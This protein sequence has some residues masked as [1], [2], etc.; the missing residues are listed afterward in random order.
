MPSPFDLA[1]NGFKLY[2]VIGLNFVRAAGDRKVFQGRTTALAKA[3]IV[4][5]T[6]TGIRMNFRK[7]RRQNLNSRLFACQSP[8][9]LRERSPDFG[10]KAL[11]PA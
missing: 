8:S 2:A 6:W 5:T 10:A 11:K 3:W 1:L 4:L 9:I 7:S